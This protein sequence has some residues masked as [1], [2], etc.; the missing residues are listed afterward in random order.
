MAAATHRQSLTVHLAVGGLLC[1]SLP[2]P[3]ADDPPACFELVTTIAPGMRTTRDQPM[4]VVWVEDVD[5]HFV[6]TLWRF[7][8]QVRWYADLTLWH[9]LSTPREAPAEV[10]AVTGATIIQGNQGFLRIPSRWHGLDLLSGRYVLHIESR[11]DQAKHYSTFRV[12][13]SVHALGQHYADP[14]YVRTI[15]LRAVA[16]GTPTPETVQAF[17][18][19]AAPPV[20]SPPATTDT[21]RTT[22]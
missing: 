22:P 12:P 1:S 11:K 14:G 17:I 2:L 5:G 13:L 6:R 8:R 10:D 16:A 9:D 3:A 20:Q 7:G 4:S 18:P 21:V 15:D 19:A